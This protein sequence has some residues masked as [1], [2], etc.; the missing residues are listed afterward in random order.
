[1]LKGERPEFCRSCYQV[2]DAGGTS[3]R[4][5]YYRL[6]LNNVGEMVRTT[7]ADGASTYPLQDLDFSLSNNCNLKCRMCNPSASYGLH[8]DFRKLEIPFNAE[9][10]EKAYTLWQYE[11]LI[12]QLIEDSDSKLK[13]ILFTGGEPLINPVHAK[14]LKALVERGL[15]QK[16]VIRY[17]SNL[18][19]VPEEIQELWAE[20]AGVQ[21]HVSLEGFGELNDY[22][23]HKS[24]WAR[25]VKNLNHVLQ[26]KK[27]TRL[28]IEIHTVFQAYNLSGII[29]FLTFLRGYSKLL[30]C[31]PH[32]IWLDNPDFLTIKALPLE[33][34][35]REIDRLEAYLLEQRSFYEDSDFAEF[36]LNKLD[37]LLAHLKRSRLTEFNEKLYTEFVLYTK[38]LDRLRNQN[39]INVAPRLAELFKE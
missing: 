14:V 4:Q 25:I 12:Q 24:E 32:F 39:I 21:L 20:F 11:G 26:L 33:L 16:I 5:D 17:H 3:V 2:E 9:S 30:P 15:S 13:Q 29:D 38:K 23:R 18:M 10:A 6:F 8:T 31:F 22:I 1:M 28:W 27:K 19:I 36:N 37:I 34:R 35:N 7:S